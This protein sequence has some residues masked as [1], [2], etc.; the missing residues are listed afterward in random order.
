MAAVSISERDLLPLALL[1]FIW[2]RRGMGFS[3]TYVND[4]LLGSWLPGMPV[5][6]ET[7]LFHRDLVV[8]EHDHHH[9]L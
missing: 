5:P 8:I 4:A 3:L 7:Q 6:P 2:G 1:G 9:A